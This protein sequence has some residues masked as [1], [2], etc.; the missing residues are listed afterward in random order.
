MHA[1]QLKTAT[2]AA[3]APAC[4]ILPYLRQCNIGSLQQ[5]LKETNISRMTSLCCSASTCT[6]NRETQGGYGEYLL[7][8]DDVQREYGLIRRLSELPAEE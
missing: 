3:E 6:R 4:V 2:S 1:S 5:T 8:A 7:F